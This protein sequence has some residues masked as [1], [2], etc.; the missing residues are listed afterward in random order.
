MRQISIQLTTESPLAIRA[1]HAPR[2]AEVASYI[3]GTAFIGGLA[4]VHRMLYP[5]D[6][7]QFE[8]LFLQELVQYPD[9]HPAMFKDEELQM[10]P[11]PVYPVPKTAQSCKRHPGFFRPRN[12]ENDA[13]GVRDSLV[14]WAMF[15]L[16]E[17]NKSLN[18]LDM[19]TKHKGCPQCKA[20]MDHFSGYYRCNPAV[21]EQIVGATIDEH[22][23]L[24][25]RTGID[26]ESGTVQEGILYNRRVFEEGMCFWGTIRVPDDEELVSDLLK[27]LNVIG[28][29]GLV[30]IGT[31]RT[32]GMGMVTFAA[33][34]VGGDEDEAR[35]PYTEFE[36]RLSLFNGLIH[37]QARENLKLED[38][39]YF[40]ALT[41]HSPLILCDEFL[42]Y[43]GT[44]DEQTLL[45]DLLCWNENIELER[46]Y[47][48][49]SV[50]R[51][52]GWQEIW[53]TPR[54]NEYAIDTGSVFLFACNVAEGSSEKDTFLR[55]L[56]ELEEQ[57]AG[58]RC[59][60]GFGRVSVSDQFHQE[61]EMR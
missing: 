22:T 40:F 61:R 58:A 4:A 18:A 25:T 24:Q 43:R 10:Q 44:I 23:H 21:S 38:S 55:K 57:G 48:A 56:F 49:A 28:S 9:L 35:D 45:E 6:K 19:L 54:M 52:T 46:V 39:R 1:D 31:G 32:R 17:K 30:R 33:E 12:E 26:R 42:R 11:Y 41:L 13:H 50:R 36:E 51:M 8:R 47:Q 15:K 7:E 14:D 34:F 3:P 53:G 37:H 20:T 60:E 2:G 27:F 16:G 29:Q 5:N 59:A